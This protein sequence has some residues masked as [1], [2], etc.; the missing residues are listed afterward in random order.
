MPCPCW[1]RHRHA[2]QAGNDC[3]PPSATGGMSQLPDAPPTR[4]RC[5]ALLPPST[6]YTPPSW[7]TT[8]CWTAPT[9]GGAHHRLIV[10]SRLSF[11]VLVLPVSERQLRSCWAMSCSPGVRRCSKARVFP[12]RPF[13]TLRRCSRRCEARCCVVSTSTL[14]PRSGPLTVPLDRH[15]C[16]PPRKCWSSS[17]PATRCDAQPSWAQR[18][19]RPRQG[20]SRLWAPTVP[21]WGEPS[22][23]ATTSSGFSGIPVS[24][25][26]PRE[27]TSGRAN[28]RCWY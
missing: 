27:T 21:W 10:V 11:R 1:R 24:R 3:A 25:E 7:F 15:R 19:A 18:S 13:A 14:R 28:A 8:T 16:T 20:C 4:I 26:N 9:P 17:P 22:S 23:C 5:C 6:C 12:Q 2:S